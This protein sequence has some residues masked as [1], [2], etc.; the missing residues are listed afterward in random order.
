MDAA[1]LLTL[2]SADRT[3]GHCMKLCKPVDR[4]T[5]D[6]TVLWFMLLLSGTVFPARHTVTNSS[7]VSS[8]KSRL[9][10]HWEVDSYWIPGTD[11][12]ATELKS[13]AKAGPTGQSAFY[14]VIQIQIIYLPT[15]FSFDI[16]LE[17]TV[18]WVRILKRGRSMIKF[19][20]HCK[21]MELHGI[22]KKI[23]LNK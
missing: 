3:R 20:R 8:F 2:N 4:L 21:K 5:S 1:G 19:D 18:H 13:S 17:Y 9:D 22:V 12:C 6:R 7:S 23:I 11:W 16:G 14:P 10:A 15:G